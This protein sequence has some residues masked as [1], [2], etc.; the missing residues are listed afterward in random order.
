MLNLQLHLDSFKFRL[1]QRVELTLPLPVEGAL[2]VIRLLVEDAAGADL[3][4]HD[5]H[6]LQTV[7]KDDVWVHGCY[8]DVVDQRLDVHHGALG[9]D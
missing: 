6:W 8:I 5:R 1:V 7:G 3:L 4:V 9:L 2:A